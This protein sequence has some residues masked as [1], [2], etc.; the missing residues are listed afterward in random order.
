MKPIVK[1]SELLEI[2]KKNREAHHEVFLKAVE[3]YQ[4]EALKRLQAK[5]KAIKAN[6]LVKMFIS[7]PIPEDKT[8]D[9]DRV[10]KMMEMDTRSEI[11]LTEQEF[12]CYVMDSWDWK[13]QWTTSNYTYITHEQLEEE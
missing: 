12:A 1:R 11:E 13:Q 3:G 2:L 8:N 7:L 9:Y 6:K 4:A 5:I 10:I